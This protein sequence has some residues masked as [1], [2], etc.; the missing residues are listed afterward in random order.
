MADIAAE[1]P[2]ARRLEEQPRAELD[3]LLCTLGF[4][5]R[6][7]SVAERLAEHGPR[8][9]S[10][11]IF[12]YETNAEANE[13][14]RE[15]LL[16]P[17][18][19][20]TSDIVELNGDSPVLSEQLRAALIPRLRPDADRTRLGWDVSVSSN[21]LIFKIASVLLDFD[22][23]L[24]V[25]YS[26]AETYFPTKEEYERERAVWAGD[27]HL[28][29]EKGTLNVRVSSE[30]PGEHSPQIG[31]H[32][33]VVAGYNRDRVRRVI[34]KID[35]QFLA[36]LP[37]APITWL[38]GKPHLP[39]DGWRRDALLDIHHVPERH[40]RVELSTFRYID[41]LLELDAIY[42]RW[43]LSHNLTLCPMGS[44]MQALGGALF[45]RSRPD[46]QVMFAQPEEYNAKRYTLGVRDVWSV[47]L[48]NTAA[49]NARLLDVG[50]VALF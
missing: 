41:T 40:A 30:H 36:D 21:Q 39:G 33:V 25:A 28:G 18:R 11:L 42:R 26:E 50:T 8:V 46:V 45:C 17:L 6:C 49:M 32:V 5:D 14:Q 43:G 22:L 4:E 34:T 10:A 9:G 38:I 19:R 2:E 16:V 35:P 1:F 20:M 7:S 47:P 29:L 3:V 23:D 15:A 12:T 44:K 37:N 27:D 13:S 48:G 24:Q 31:K